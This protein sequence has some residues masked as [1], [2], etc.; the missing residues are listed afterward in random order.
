MAKPPV[1]PDDERDNVFTRAFFRFLRLFIGYC[2]VRGPEKG[3]YFLLPLWG[4]WRR[5]YKMQ[6]TC[7]RCHNKYL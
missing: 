5:Y 6:R 3:H 1:S 4:K 7:K 2:D